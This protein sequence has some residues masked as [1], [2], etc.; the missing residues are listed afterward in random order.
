MELSQ[1]SISREVS[2]YYL[3]CQP[4][5]TELYPFRELVLEGQHSLEGAQHTLRVIN[6]IAS[7]YYSPNDVD[8]IVDGLFKELYNVESYLGETSARAECQPIQTHWMK[9]VD[10]VCSTSLFGLALLL[11]SALVS[12]LLFTLLVGFDSHTWIYIQRRKRYLQQEECVSFLPSQ[13]DGGP[14]GTGTG[15][16]TSSTGQRCR[17]SGER[18]AGSNSPYNLVAHWDTQPTPLSMLTRE[19][20]V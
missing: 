7:N 10:A 2:E 15:T 1:A 4:F 18:G 8:E 5:R 20:R 14:S 19:S 13:Y 3:N 17:R 9:G 12:A 6:S 16:G 11:V